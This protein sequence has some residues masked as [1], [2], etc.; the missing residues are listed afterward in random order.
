LVTSYVDVCDLDS[1]VPLPDI[2]ISLAAELTLELKTTCAWDRGASEETF[3]L[4]QIQSF[5]CSNTVFL[6]AM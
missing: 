2:D 6:M 5:I 3:K 4:L 1:L